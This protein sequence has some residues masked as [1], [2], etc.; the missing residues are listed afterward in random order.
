MLSN[1]SFSPAL[2]LVNF[3]EFIQ[4]FLVPTDNTVFY[5]NPTGF[6][7]SWEVLQSEFLSQHPQILW[8]REEKYSEFYRRHSGNVFVMA[9]FS[10]NFDNELKLLATSLTRLRSVRVLI[11]MQ[12][13]ESSFLASQILSLCWQH[14]ML[15]VAL[16]FQYWNSPITIFSYLAFPYFT[17]VR[18]T[19]SNESLPSIF[20][21]QL[22][23][24]RGYQIRV[25]PDLSPPNSFIYR[26]KLGKIQFGGFMWRI[27]DSYAKSL[28]AGIHIL[29]PSWEK[30]KLSSSE[31]MMEFTRNGSS[32]FGLTS[33]M[34]VYKFEERFLDSTYPLFHSNWCA[35][36]PMEKPLSVDTLFK[37]VLT[38]GLFYLLILAS[39]FC[40][41]AVPR[42]RRYLRITCRGRLFRLASRVIALV[43]VCATSAQL[44]S[45]LIKPPLH[46]KIETFD[47]LLASGL[48]IFGMTREFYFLDGAFRAKYASAFH[49]T[50]NVNELM[51]L[52]NYFNTSW[53]YTITSVKW[54]VIEAQQKHFSHPIFR[55]SDTM[56]FDWDSPCSIII[57]PESIYR[58][59]FHRYTLMLHQAGL[60]H[61]WMTHSYYDMVKAGRMILKDYSQTIPMD[62]LSPED[63]GTY[64]GILAIG[65]SSSIAVFTIELLL[66]YT[67][68]FLNSL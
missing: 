55:Y 9:C 61:Y 8:N 34:I 26:D 50:D 59:S 12:E 5:F 37:R 3:F 51:D 68:V 2:E 32:D 65:L 54:T 30:N 60:I 36:L 39:L 53:A 13:K 1:L 28:G 64:W 43:M 57:A 16:Y 22:A 18:Q 49:L 58:G 38:P 41:L 24:L 63:L 11:E 40:Y 23:D 46:S 10:R 7:C 6:N 25:Q 45:L 17:L 19:L 47:D 14:D 48:K 31:Y 15:N 56:C 21:N 4:Q 67:N 35:M 29:Y 42:I 27:F 66:F 33:T 44:L 20:T 62:A 52:R